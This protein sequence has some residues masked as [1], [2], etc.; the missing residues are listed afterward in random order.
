MVDKRF[1]S[2][3]QIGNDLG[4]DD[5][6]YWFDFKQRKFL[7][8]IDTFYYSVKFNNDFT[9]DTKDRAVKHYRHFFD[10]N[11]RELD[12]GFGGSKTLYFDNMQK[13][14]NLRPFNFAGYY[15]VC[16]EC[17][18]WFDI[19]M[20]KSVPCGADGGTSVTCE[21]VIQIRS[22]MLWIYGVHGAFE[23]SMEYVQGLADYFNLDVDYVQENRVDYCWHT[24]YLANPETFFR[25]D[26]FYRMRCDRYKG[27]TMHTAKVG[28]DGYE[29]DY[30]ALGKRSD[31]VFL[32][33]YLKSK[34]VVEQGYKPWFFKVWL[35]NGLIN[36]YDLYIYEQ[37]FLERSWQY[38]DMARI[39]Y[40]FEYGTDDV[41]RQCC[42]NILDGVITHAPDTL[43][44]IADSLT[45]R[46]NLVIN[47]EYQTMRR[48]SKS[49][50]LLPFKNNSSKGICQR[51]YDYLDNRALITNYLTHDVFRLVEP[52]GD[53][54]KSRRDYVGFWRALRSCKTVDILVPPDNIK[55]VR[56]YN[57]RLSSQIVKERM[58]KASVTY[59][60]YTKGI[61][62][63]NPAND[64]LDALCVLNDNDIQD[65]IRFK[66]KKVRQF[67]VTELA[68]VED[69]VRQSLKVVDT[70]TGMLLDDYIMDNNFLQ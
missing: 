37:C 38:L 34:E 58:I 16:L 24:N 40:Y 5:I 31:K 64:I 27:A 32:R 44:R 10:M 54:N 60:I 8:N 52:D 14:L 21:W 26:N 43:R 28:T 48:H 3:T 41:Q 35:F 23:R 7:Q 15:T 12:S 57:R 25:T 18:D 20:A 13:S 11:Q 9:S 61:N 56:M 50:A 70:H 36:R 22:Y 51:V 47:V 6:T 63:D 62:T 19:F 17:P 29:I 55:L 42:K 30:I 46:V 68:D 53:K 39:K 33:I 65:A 69:N 45:P 67:N 59:G 49:Y 2:K 66:Q 1:I 4:S